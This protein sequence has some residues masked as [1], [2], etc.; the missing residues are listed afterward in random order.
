[1]MATWVPVATTPVE[2]ADRVP[3]SPSVRLSVTAWPGWPLGK[4]SGTTFSVKLV[5][6]SGF[7][8][9]MR[10]PQPAKPSAIR[11]IAATASA[12][13]AKEATLVPPAKRPSLPL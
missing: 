6:R 7:W 1:M 5:S 9:T 8:A 11:S 4:V 12:W 10:L 2:T 13:L 3:V